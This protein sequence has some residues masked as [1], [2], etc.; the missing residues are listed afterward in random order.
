MARDL[1]RIG[2]RA[3]KGKEE[4]FTSIYHYVTDL[5]HLRACYTALPAKSAAGVDGVSKEEYGQ[6]LERKLR[7]LSERLGRMGYRPQPVRRTYI[8]KPGTDKKRSLGI[9][10][11]EDKVVS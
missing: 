5:E 8:P 2:E 1:T 6:D 10:C 3:R 4:R 7:D 11:S 9:M